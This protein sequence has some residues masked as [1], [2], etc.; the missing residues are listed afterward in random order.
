PELRREQL[1]FHGLVDGVAA[2]GAVAVHGERK[3]LLRVPKE[4]LLL[5]EKH[6]AELLAFLRVEH[7]R[8]PQI[9]RH[10][11]P[12]VK[13]LL[14]VLFGVGCWVLAAVDLRRLSSLSR[15]AGARAA[16]R[17]RG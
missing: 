15:G 9:Y 3:P 14:P 5:E 12:D 2:D 7:G 8:P 1:L 6:L 13:P 10:S 16:R 11:F 4:P 17:R